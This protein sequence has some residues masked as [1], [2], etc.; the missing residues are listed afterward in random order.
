MN[1]RAGCILAAVT[2]GV[3]SRTL[4]QEAAWQL[5]PFARPDGANPIIQPQKD[6]IFFCPIRNQNVHWEALHTFNP[7]AI[8]RNGKI[9]VLYRAEDDTG[10]MAIG[11]HTSRLGLAES[12]DGIHFTR[13]A[14][15]VFYPAQ[16]DQ[17]DR[18]WPGGCEDPRLV[19]SQDGTY[20]LTYT[21]WNRKRTA[22]AIATSRDLVT[23]SKHGPALSGAKYAELS[24]KSAGIVSKLSNGRLIAAKIKGKYWMYWGEGAVRLATSTDLIHWDPIETPDGDPIVVLAKRPARFDSSFPEVGPPPILTERGIIVIYNGKNDPESGDPELG[25]N[26]YAAG[27][28]LFAADDPTRLLA[29]SEQPFFKPQMPFEK[30][31]QY[32]AGTTFVEGLVFFNR[33]WFL[34]YGC[35]DSLVGV[36]ATP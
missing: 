4:A 26:A 24:Y 19:E 28:A 12:N 20:V 6:S 23:W 13:R 16:D 25:P 36:A 18:E 14:T 17:K 35:A 2:L 22:A 29:R 8:V 30:T 7:A 32:K 15:P 34:Y 33:K 9:Y 21:Q 3:T 5:G 27:Q 10:E 31:G 11:G 1:I